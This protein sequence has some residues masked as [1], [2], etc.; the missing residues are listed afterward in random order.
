M[1]RKTQYLVSTPTL[2]ILD[3]NEDR[4]VISCP[5]DASIWR[6]LSHKH[7]VYTHELL[8]TGILK[9]EMDWDNDKFKVP[10]SI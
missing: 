2:R 5:E 3:A 9:Q 4:H 8:L 7:P 6:Q 1:T 10:G